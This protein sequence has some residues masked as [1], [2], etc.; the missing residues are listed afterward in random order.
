MVFLDLSFYDFSREVWVYFSKHKSKVFSC[1]MTWCTRVEN[2][3]GKKMK[4]L[5]TDDM[6]KFKNS[7]FDKFCAEH[8]ICHHV[9]AKK[10]P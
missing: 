6:T 8:G 1:F 2:Q 5:W 9:M 10:T 3:M 4:V 7:E